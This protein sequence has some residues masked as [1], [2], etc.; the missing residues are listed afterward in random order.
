[1]G[2]GGADRDMTIR[3]GDA[4]EPG[5]TLHVHEVARPQQAFL[6]QQEELGAAGVRDRVVT[7][8]REQGARFVSVRRPMER[9]RAQH[10]L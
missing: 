5:N 4:V 10:R 3:G 2:D 1:M 6:H 8:L 9:E 7:E